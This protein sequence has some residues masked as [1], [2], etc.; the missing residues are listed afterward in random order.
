MSSRRH[1]FTTSAPATIRNEAGRPLTF[2]D[3]VNNETTPVEPSSLDRAMCE[4]LDAYTEAARELLENRYASQRELA[5]PN[6]RAPCSV[7]VARCKDGILVRYDLAQEG[8]ERIAGT[9][10]DSPLAEVSPH[11][12][13]NLIH[14]PQ[15]PRFYAPTAGGLTLALVVIDSKTGA[16]AVHPAGRLLIYAT[17]TIPEGNNVPLPPARPPRFAFVHNEM[18]FHLG[19]FLVPSDAPMD[20]T[21]PHADHFIT[22]SRSRLPVGWQAIEIYPLLGE[23]YWKPEYAPAWAELD[24]LAEITKRNVLAT[25]LNEIDGRGSARRKYAALLEELDGLL[26]GP[27]EPAHQFLKS[28][29]DL[30]SATYDQ[31]W[32]K[33][34]FGDH[35]SDFVFREPYN[36]YLLVEIEAPIRELFRKDGDQRRELT[37]A[38][39]QIEDWTR[40]IEENKQSVEAEL[41]LTGISANPRTLVV[42][43]RS[44]SLTEENRRKLVSVQANHNKLRIVTYDDLI[45]AARAN[46]ERILGPLDCWGQNVQFYFYK[47]SATHSKQG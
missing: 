7:L 37:H 24:L 38:I 20:P 10:L 17:S 42:I 14:F 19:G 16:K 2:A 21:S 15:D 9:I 5:P 36:D 41:G 40:Y 46:I 26:A 4:T 34:R 28:H 43:G 29:P 33:L 47:E 11:L 3:A 32:S 1:Q 22:H 13:D 27:E 12:S 8:Q 30:L 25:T 18:D 44:A 23:E 45:A 35:I 6:M 31:F 39:S